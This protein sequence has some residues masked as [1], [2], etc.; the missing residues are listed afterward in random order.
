MFNNKQLKPDNYP[1]HPT[2]HT[3]YAPIHHISLSHLIP[4]TYGKNK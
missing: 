2:P 1:I 3:L 4:S